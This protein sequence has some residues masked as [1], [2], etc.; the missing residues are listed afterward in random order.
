M[1]NKLIIKLP[2][3][4]MDIKE[5]LRQEIEAEAQR[6]EKRAEKCTLSEAEIEA[7]T[8]EVWE[9]LQTEIAKREQAERKKSRG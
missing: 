2:G 3:G 7:A 6:A 8:S 1:Y 9:R 4:H 5:I